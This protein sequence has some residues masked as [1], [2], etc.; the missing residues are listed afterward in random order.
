MIIYIYINF[1][2]REIESVVLPKKNV[3]F[4]L[5]LVVSGAA[6]LLI[7]TVFICLQ[8]KGYVYQ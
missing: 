4:S 1:E 8:K 6:A 2:R 7:V 5:G 3:I